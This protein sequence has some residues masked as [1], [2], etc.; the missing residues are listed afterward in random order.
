MSDL[1]ARFQ[2]EMEAQ[3]SQTDPNTERFEA[4]SVRLKKTNIEVQLVAL[5]WIPEPGKAA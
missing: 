1:Q 5:G 3:Q 2:S 4:V